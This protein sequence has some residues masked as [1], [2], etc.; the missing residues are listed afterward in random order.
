MAMTQT[1]YVRY[2]GLT[3]SRVC[4]LVGAGMPLDSIEAANAFRSK[5]PR[6]DRSRSFQ[7]S[8]AFDTLADLGKIEARTRR[9]FEQI[10]TARAASIA[11]HP[12]RLASAGA[13][14]A[15]SERIVAEIWTDVF[16]ALGES[17]PL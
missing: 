2:S 10:S 5:L 8:A 12:A 3:K 14:L 7:A 17:S 4:Q 1:D 16:R 9:A 6:A 13:N 11:M 15:E